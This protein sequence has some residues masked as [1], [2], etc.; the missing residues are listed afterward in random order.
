MGD[1]E[2]GVVMGLPPPAVPRRLGR[3]VGA[4]AH[5]LDCSPG[6]ALAAYRRWPLTSAPWSAEEALALVS[7]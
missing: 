7:T 5:A 2:I 1:A 6:D 3:A 4:L